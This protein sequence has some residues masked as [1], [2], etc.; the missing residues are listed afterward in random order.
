MGIQA[1]IGDV[2]STLGQ[3]LTSIYD[4][5]TSLISGFAG[6]IGTFV[7]NI[8]DSGFAGV[9]NFDS[10]KAAINKYSQN[11][12]NIVN[13]YNENADLD[14]TFKGKAGESMHTFVQNTKTLLQAFVSLVEQ[15]NNEL[16]DAYAKYQSGDTSLSASVESD[17]QAVAEKAQ[18]INLG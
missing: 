3:V 18:N 14:S 7:A 12:Q 6:Q 15:W 11:I 10:L 9:S 4:N 2:Q 17:A 8:W 5:A 1:I 13:E 16:D